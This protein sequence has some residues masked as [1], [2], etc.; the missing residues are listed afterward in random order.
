MEFCCRLFF[1]P[2]AL[3]LLFAWYQIRRKEDNLE[4][5]LPAPFQSLFSDQF[6]G[7][8]KVVLRYL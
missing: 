6:L 8:Q 4:Q 3:K 7:F 5:F 2:K 1:R